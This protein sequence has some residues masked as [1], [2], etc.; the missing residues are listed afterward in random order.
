M[1]DSQIPPWRTEKRE[2][3][4]PAEVSRPKSGTQ[5]P[6]WAK[7]LFE[8]QWRYISVRGG[9]GSGK[10]KNFARA[11]IMRSTVAP[12]RVLC[13][14]EI[15][16]SIRES[17][18]ATLVNEIKELGLESQFEILSNEIRSKRGGT[19]IFRGLAAETIDS[20]KSLADIDIAWVEEAQSVSHKSFEMLFP[21]IRANNSQIWLSWNPELETDPIYE[22]VIKKGLPKCANLFVNFDQ[23]PWFPEVLRLEEQHMLALDPVRHAHVWGGLPLPAVAGAIYFDEIMRMMREERIRLLTLDPLLQ[24]YAVFDLGYNDAMTCGIVQKTHSDLRII[25]YIENDRVSLQWFD[26]ELRARGYESAIIVF[27]HDG[28]NKSLQT[29]LSP[30]E[31]MQ[32]YGWMVEICDNVGVENGIRLCRELMGTMYIDE[33]RCAVLL[34]HLKRY[35]RN[36]HGH[37]THDEHSHA[38]DMTRYIAVHANMMTST[39]QGGG[40]GGG[41]GQDLN[42][43]KIT[44]G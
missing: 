36:K 8:P 35:A 19:F 24:L 25:D 5:M 18:Y 20:I 7:V 22:L 41:W 2:S 9:R 38:A 23:N 34:E 40:W 15:Q 21:T 6:Q 11:L 27:P 42:Y 28:R 33:V 37:P 43:P 3:D 29:A 26:T 12:L 10:T 13:T 32:M 44:T 16:L 39:F 4:V 31:V 14:R 30:Q 1:M 17:V